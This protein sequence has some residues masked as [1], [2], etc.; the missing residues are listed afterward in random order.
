MK[1]FGGFVIGAGGL[2][3]CIELTK[4]VPLVSL[5]Y[6]GP[7]PAIAVEANPL[8]ARLVIYVARGVENVFSVGAKSKVGAATIETVIVY[9]IDNQPLLVNRS[10][11]KPMKKNLLFHKAGRNVTVYSL[12]PAK[13]RENQVKVVVYD[14]R[15]RRISKFQKSHRNSVAAKSRIKITLRLLWNSF[16]T[17]KASS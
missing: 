9:V 11:D 7:E 12:V 15:F 13:L 14:C 2:F 6:I 10:H 3:G 16:P 1:F 17:K 8:K 4:T 5:A